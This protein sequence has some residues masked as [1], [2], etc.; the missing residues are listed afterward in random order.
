MATKA[1]AYLAQARSDL[2]AYDVSGK[3][4]EPVIAEHHRLHLLQMAL[5]KLAKSFLYDAA[6]AADFNH[7][8]VL[9]AVNVLRGNPAAANASGAAT[10]SAFR[11]E[12]EAAKPVLLL[13]EAASPSVGFDGRTL[14]REESERTANVEYPW[15]LEPNDPTS[16]VSPATRPVR[17]LRRL[18]EDRNTAVA[19]RLLRRLF[20]V[21]EAVLPED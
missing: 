2:E 18:R 4:A 20:A 1:R 17:L 15:Q 9:K 13:I 3:A 19:E 7:S 8:V 10:L 14:R 12:L 16:W 21:A 6:P 11:R 5:E